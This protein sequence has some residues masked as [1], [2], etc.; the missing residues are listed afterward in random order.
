MDKF[1]SPLESMYSSLDI[2]GNINQEYMEEL[3]N[4]P[5]IE[6]RSSLNDEVFYNPVTKRYEERDRALTGNVRRK[7]QDVT[8]L[9][10]QGLPHDI[11]HEANLT[12][13]ALKNACPV[14]IPFNDINVP[15]GSRWI[16]IKYYKK[17][18]GDNNTGKF[19]SDK[20]VYSPINDDFIADIYVSHN[21]WYM[22]GHMSSEILSWA[23]KRRVPQFTEE[24]YDSA[25]SD[26][27]RRFGFSLPA[28]RT[29]DE[30][31]RMRAYEAVNAIEKDWQ[32]WLNK[33][34]NQNIRDGIEEIY[35]NFFNCEVRPK[36]DGSF[37]TFPGLELENLGINDLYP[38]QKDAIW[39]I[40]Q[41]NGGV[42][43]HQVGSG[44]T[45]VMCIAAYEL[46]RIGICK[47]PIIICM[48]ANIGQIADTFRKAYPKAR[49]LYPSAKE[50][51]KVN[52]PKTILRLC[53]EDWD[54]II[55][56]H[57][58]FCQLPAAISS[59]LD[60]LS[61]EIK[62]IENTIQ[63]CRKEHICGF[64]LKTSIKSIKS[65][66]KLLDAKNQKI[67]KLL[68][69]RFAEKIDFS[70]TGIDHIFVDEYH[71]FKNLTFGTKS[72]G[73]SGVGTPEGSKKAWFLYTAIRDIQSRKHSDLCATFASGTII[74][75]S[76][77]ELYVLFKYL[78]PRALERQNIFSF[79]AWATIFCEK[80]FD[81]ELDIVGQLKSKERF[82][83]FLNLPELSQ[84]L[85]QI[86]D[87]RTTR[88]CGI[89]VPNK[90][91]NFDSA[92]PT[93]NQKKFF[94]NLLKF[95]DTKKWDDLQIKKDKPEN[96][97]HSIML[98][99]TNLARQASLDPRCLDNCQTFKDE[100]GNK[101]RRCAKNIARIYHYHEENL[102]T[103]FVFTDLST[104]DASKW[105][106]QQ[107]LEDILVREYH[108][109]SSQVQQINEAT[110]DSKRVDLFN[111]MNNGEVR[112]LIG[113][114]T[115]LGTGVNAQKRAV[116]VHHLDIPWRPSDV[117]QRNGR[118]IRNGN[119]VG[120]WG[121]NEVEVYFYATERSL[122][123]YKFNLL[124]NKQM[125]IEQLNKGTIGVRRIDDDL[126][127]DDNRAV[128]YAEFLAILSGNKDL[129]VKARLD[130]EILLM[131][132]NR[133]QFYKERNS[134]LSLIQK[135]NTDIAL[136]SQWLSAA[137][138]D[139]AFAHNISPDTLPIFSFADNECS[140]MHSVGKFVFKL[141][142]SF[143]QPEYTNIG[144]YGCFEICARRIATNKNTTGLLQVC[145]LGESGQLYIFPENNG[146]PL[147][148]SFETAAR[149]A[150][151]IFTHLSL[152][153]ETEESYIQ[154][155]K[156]EIERLS[157]M[158]KSEWSGTHKLQ[159]LYEELSAVVK[160]IKEFNEANKLN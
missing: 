42:C 12:L 133:A 47:K 81:F 56:T 97:S 13:E 67:N 119:D 14:T 38:S 108:I 153:I 71:C 112:V 96:V 70:D 154:Q 92:P 115:R 15:I 117:E 127:G 125:F 107:E 78:R 93:D 11:E 53:E 16:P 132:K 68:S 158:S 137:K 75:N 8:E 105:N 24:I 156:I 134:A 23:I 76:L 100:P 1:L 77:T 73:T 129:L 34:K 94:D 39:M 118:A 123:A 45:L 61:R 88:M 40:K 103:Q 102:G 57:E 19:G 49:L 104:L 36:Y 9:I 41:N 99:A 138:R 26:F 62:T 145:L 21:E 50:W 84:F 18:I 152:L 27:R 4:L 5:W 30:A 2:Y 7:I 20:L 80:K 37:Q 114:T 63:E 110:T 155:T 65:L 46:K 106:I 25:R 89:E 83:S 3:T 35:N 148:S 121:N 143:T 17:F 44:K 55:L 43:W 128:S 6:V 51:T 141:I 95:L 130:A 111:R 101:V 135:H 79:D 151:D 122:D 82:A 29:A 91:E 52:R 72:S 157:L 90:K 74:T 146:Q 120:I 131:E 48:K 32:N 28:K 98:L 109:P 160:R 64:S 144:K 66:E 58:Q 85:S 136:K 31:K 33:K 86:T 54:C 159:N 142:D 147:R 116:A 139:L 149:F 140:N 113:S 126:Y 59:E 124:K 69:Q 10:N 87:Y 22:L 150:F 60:I